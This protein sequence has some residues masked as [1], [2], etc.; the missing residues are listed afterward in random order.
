M[1]IIEKVNYRSQANIVEL[2]NV[3]ISLLEIL[4]PT[5]LDK[6]RKERPFKKGTK[7]KFLSNKDLLLKLLENLDQKTKKNEENKEKI[8]QEVKPK[9]DPTLGLSYVVLVRNKEIK[10]KV[11]NYFAQFHCPVFTIYESKVRFFN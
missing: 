6:I 1:G 9:E 8:L 2:S 3:I 5:S 11:E 4:F 10:K 7:S